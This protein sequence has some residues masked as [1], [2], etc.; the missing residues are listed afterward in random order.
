MFIPFGFFISYILKILKVK[1]AILFTIITSLTIEVTQLC[2]GRVFDIDDVLL[3]ILGGI[4]GFYMYYFF[5]IIKNK[6]KTLKI[7]FIYNTLTIIGLG[8]FIYASLYILIF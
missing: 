1:H 4:I 5:H 8:L 7:P 2:I 3:N 6:S